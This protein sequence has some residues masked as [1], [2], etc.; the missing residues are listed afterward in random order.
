MRICEK[1]GSSLGCFLF[2]RGNKAYRSA[3]EREHHTPQGGA[4][5]GGGITEEP[6]R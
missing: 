4:A 6:D 3:N 2:M 5:H 1:T